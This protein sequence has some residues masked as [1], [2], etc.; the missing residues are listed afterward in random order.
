MFIELDV[1]DSSRHPNLPLPTFY[2]VADSP[3]TISITGVPPALGKASITQ[4]YVEI[5]YPDETTET[6]HCV[7][8]ADGSWTATLGGNETVGKTR[9]GLKILADGKDEMGVTVV[10]WVLGFGD[11]EILDPTASAM[12]TPST[13]IDPLDDRY[14]LKQVHDKVNEIISI[15]AKSITLVA[16]IGAALFASADERVTKAQLDELYNDSQVVTDVDLSGISVTEVD[17]TVGLT[18]GTIYIHGEEITPLVAHQSLEGVTNYV[19]AATN[20]VMTSVD[21]KGYLASE[22]DPTVAITNGT[23]YIK[24]EKVTPVSPSDT[25]ELAEAKL[26]YAKDFSAV[27][28]NVGAEQTLVADLTDWPDGQAQIVFITLATGA[29][30]H[31]AIQLVGYPDWVYDRTFAASALLRKN[32]VYISPLFGIAE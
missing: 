7:C 13:H 4:V 11:V 12:P 29:S 19:D 27:A 23:I 3:L 28:V 24:G 15:L 22:S 14:N 1:Y 26:G 8:E 9:G 32:K 5:T 20:A 16:V 31:E 17:P 18:N 10:G 30:V 25:R 21:G 6:V 2:G